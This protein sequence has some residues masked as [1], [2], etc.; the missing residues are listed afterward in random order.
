[1]TSYD[2]TAEEILDRLRNGNCP[3][4]FAAAFS[5]RI[6]DVLEELLARPVVTA[7][8]NLHSEIEEALRVKQDSLDLPRGGANLWPG[9]AA[10]V[11]YLTVI[12]HLYGEEG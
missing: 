6:A 10:R 7:N 8:N 9:T 1:M 4:G 2:Y 12:D 11:A 3:S 5:G